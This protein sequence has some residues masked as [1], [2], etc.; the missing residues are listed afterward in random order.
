[1][2]NT[3]DGNIKLRVHS[4]PIKERHNSSSSGVGGLGFRRKS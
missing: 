3:F 4:D 2:M 1:M